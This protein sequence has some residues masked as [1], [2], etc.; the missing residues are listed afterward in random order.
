M[1]KTLKQKIYELYKE[2]ERKYTEEDL[3]RLMER[4]GREKT[5]IEEAKEYWREIKQIETDFNRE[6]TIPMFGI[7]LEYGGYDTSVTSELIEDT[8]DD[9]SVQGDGLEINLFPVKN[10][11]ENIKEFKA[12][13]KKMMERAEEGNCMV[14]P[15]AGMHVHVSSTSLGG[16]EG[17]NIVTITKNIFERE[18]VTGIKWDDS[19]S[20]YVY[21]DQYE[22]E[23]CYVDKEEYER[24]INEG[25]DDEY[26]MIRIDGKARLKIKN[27]N[28]IEEKYKKQFEWIKFLCSTSEREGFEEYGLGRDITRGY[29]GHRTIELRVWRTTLDYRKL[30]ARA[31]I[32]MF[33]IYFVNKHIRLIHKG[34][35]KYKDVDIWEE[36]K[37]DTKAYDAYQYLAFCYTN[38]HDI[39]YTEQELIDKLDMTSYSA[40]AIKELSRIENYLQFDLIYKEA[41]DTINNA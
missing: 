2:N 28:E 19:E 23:Y 22:D 20:K 6:K 17:T 35:E 40:K 5:E 36:L 26:L 25:Y 11:E 9:G 21:K 16:Q 41:N 34:Y 31:T 33:W 32:A 30:T 14:H 7:E 4:A 29:T 8:K 10:T 3:E 15:S 39:G 1:K 12:K 13:A 24:M 37:K 27:E 38:H 18:E